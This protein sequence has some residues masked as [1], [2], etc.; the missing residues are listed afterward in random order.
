MRCDTR[1]RRTPQT[2]REPALTTDAAAAK[3]ATPEGTG[4][5]LPLKEAAAALHVSEKYYKELHKDDPGAY[6][7][8][9]VGIFWRVPEAFLR[10]KT[11]WP[12]AATS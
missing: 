1:R 12:P 8:T 11:A 10:A 6:P 7:L 9:R 4:R 2:I 3:P 5:L